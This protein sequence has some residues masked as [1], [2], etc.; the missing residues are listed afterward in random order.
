MSILNSL[1]VLVLL[2]DVS[3]DFWIAVF[4][5][6]CLRLIHSPYFSSTCSGVQPFFGSAISREPVLN[7]HLGCL[8]L[9]Y[10]TV[11]CGVFRHSSS[12]YQLFSHTANPSLLV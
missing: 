10:S 8:T 9:R 1:S 12:H 2:I 7:S 3:V 5:V 11:Y 6:A 4:M